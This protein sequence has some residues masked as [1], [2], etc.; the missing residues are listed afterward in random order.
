MIPQFYEIT[1]RKPD[2]V[3]DQ[4]CLVFTQTQFSLISQYL[5]GV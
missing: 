1:F 2:F 4:A 3:T 5:T